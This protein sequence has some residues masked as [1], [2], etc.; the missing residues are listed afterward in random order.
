MCVHLGMMLHGVLCLA[1]EVGAGGGW[2]LVSVEGVNEESFA[3]L[4]RAGTLSVHLDVVPVPCSD[5]I[6]HNDAKEDESHI[7]TQEDVC[8]P[9]VDG[10]N[11]VEMYGEEGDHNVRENAGVH[12]SSINGIA[13]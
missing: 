3:F 4:V 6:L 12:P 9:R 10:R 7:S 11:L 5:A 8:F 13:E 2:K 1:C